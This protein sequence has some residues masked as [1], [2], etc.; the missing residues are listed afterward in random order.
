MGDLS[1]AGGAL[2]INHG[3]GGAPGL[4]FTVSGWGRRVPAECLRAHSTWER[5]LHC[6]GRPMTLSDGILPELTQDPTWEGFCELWT[7]ALSSKRDKGGRVSP[8]CLI[9]RGLWAVLA[10]KAPSSSR[11]IG[12]FKT[13]F[14]CCLYDALL[15]V[16]FGYKYKSDN[17]PINEP[18]LF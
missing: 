2:K 9:G 14:S 4:L 11:S 18:S 3:R 16:N 15:N 10:S 6:M 8:F 17:E 5:F 12:P 7:Q 13:N 1:V